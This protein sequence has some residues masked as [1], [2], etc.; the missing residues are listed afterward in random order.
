MRVRKM[1]S[2]GKSFDCADPSD[3]Q[4]IERNVTRCLK[5]DHDVRPV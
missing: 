2:N 5:M 4:I 1:L 3:E